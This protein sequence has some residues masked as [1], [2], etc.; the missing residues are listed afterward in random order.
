M[1]P[2]RENQLPAANKI[3]VDRE[4]PQMIF[5]DAAFVIPTDRSTVCVFYGVGGQRKTALCRELWQATYRSGVQAVD[6]RAP[7]LVD[8]SGRRAS[9][10][11]RY[12]TR[13]VFDRLI[14]HYYVAIGQP[15]SDVDD[16][17]FIGADISGWWYSIR[18][19]PAERIF[20]RFSD[21]QAGW[22]R[23]RWS[24]MALM[25]PSLGRLV[26]THG[27]L[28]TKKISCDATTAFSNVNDPTLAAA[29][30]AAFGVDPLSG[31]GLALALSQGFV[32]A[33]SILECLDGR[34][35]ALAHCRAIQRRE[36]NRLL[37]QKFQMYAQELRWRSAP[38]WAARSKF[39]SGMPMH[40]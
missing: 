9:A 6:V 1:A 11:R 17:L 16:R 13:L 34:Q 25:S 24:D 35:E 19:G 12:G 20:C 14:C 7:I 26:K 28:L 18:T 36:F 4:F 5:E 3:F 22:G 15:G 37:M 8:C 40:P 23:D 30:D 38:F 32:V 33:A 29:G 21:D 27:Y 10:V 31:Q 2:L 39:H